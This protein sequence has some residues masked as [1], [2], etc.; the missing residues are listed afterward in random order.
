MSSP[1]LPLL[2]LPRIQNFA[3]VWVVRVPKFS[4]APVAAIALLVQLFVT[5]SASAALHRRAS[6]RLPSR[7]IKIGVLA[8]ESRAQ[9]TVSKALKANKRVQLASNEELARA[10][11]AFRR[12]DLTEKDYVALSEE[13]GIAAFAVAQVS[14][15]KQLKLTVAIRNGDD[16][17]VLAEAEWSKLSPN[18]LKAVQQTFWKTLGPHIRKAKAHQPTQSTSET[19]PTPPPS[20]LPGE[21]AAA[22]EPEPSPT[23][24][25]AL[26]PA[27]LADS[28]ALAA[29]PTTS[30]ATE[31]SPPT[32]QVAQVSAFDEADPQRLTLDAALG[33]GAFSRDFSYSADA[34]ALGSYHLNVGPMVSG[35]LQFYPLALLT[36]GF[37]SWF[38]LVG[39]GDYAV[40]LKS[41]AA[42]GPSLNT[43][44]YRYSGGLKFRFPIGRSEVGLSASYG[45]TKF[46]IQG[47]NPPIGSTA[48]PDVSYRFVLPELSARIGVLRTV[49]VL[50]GA[51]YMQSLGS[52]G[53]ISS[54]AFFPHATA[55]GLSGSLGV[56]WEVT[57]SLE[58]RFI[59]EY[60]RVSLSMNSQPTD[61][62]RAQGAVDQYLL[63]RGTFAYRWK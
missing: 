27:P 10:R 49:W 23:S 41:A 22:K 13:H 2:T 55:K 59:A 9:N 47:Q 29:S 1:L 50:A 58:L 56:A 46:S 20:P 40:G 51:S 34:A 17:A 16:G 39:S 30:A 6:S 42:N 45:T 24:V 25:A 33:A 48:I 62:L 11:I 57:S 12:H 38:G 3:I 32:T 31:P 43:S 18:R 53:Q 8:K 35:T 54:S 7:A 4:A 19:P 26:S 52:I 15:R 5:F 21:P 63:G 37:P 28:H 61:P 44:A 60:D 14:G 36:S